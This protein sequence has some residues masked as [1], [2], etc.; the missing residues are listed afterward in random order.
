MSERTLIA[1]SSY[2][3]KALAKSLS[4]RKP[5]T[6]SVWR[7]RKPSIRRK[8]KKRSTRHY[9]RDSETPK[10]PRKSGGWGFLEGANNQIRPRKLSCQWAVCRI[11]SA[12][13]A[14]NAELGTALLLKGDA[15]GALAEI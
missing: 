14:A 9:K 15:Q 11:L 7:I 13:G 4:T 8:Q 2:F 1:L 6:I 10:Q 12:T 3:R 5:C